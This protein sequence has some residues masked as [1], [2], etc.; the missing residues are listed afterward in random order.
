MKK[1]FLIILLGIIG[2][3]ARSQSIFML[4][5]TTTPTPVV[6][7][8]VI[9]LPNFTNVSGTSP[10]AQTFTTSGINLVTGGTV[11]CPSWME[12]SIDNSTWSTPNLFFSLSSGGFAGQ[13]ITV[14]SRTQASTAPGSYSGN[15]SVVSGTASKNVAVTATVSAASGSHDTVEVNLWDGTIGQVVTTGWNNWNPIS[16]GFNGTT[17]ISTTT[18]GVFNYSTG[19]A[20]PITATFSIGG[21][22]D[23]QSF[24]TDNGTPYAAASTSTYPNLAFRVPYLFTTGETSGQDTLIFNNLPAAANNYTIEII[25][26]RATSSGRTESFTIGSTTISFTADNNL[27]N[28][29]GGF[30]PI[31]WTN[32]SPDVN[33][34]I[35]VV[36]AYTNSF[37]FVNAFKIIK[38]D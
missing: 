8:S 32:V 38:N 20:S 29:V 34:Q 22:S 30:V 12:L 31:R 13:P 37:S 26:S 1:L 23:V 21:P 6:N 11:T 35:K 24:Y 25:S 18:S 16:L 5:Y 9:T 19:T 14:Y 10:T 17:T 3:S 33:N 15:I 36:I 27:N 2:L 28:L 7:T 4:T